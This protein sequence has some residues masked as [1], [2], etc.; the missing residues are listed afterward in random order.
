MKSGKPDSQGNFPEDSRDK[1]IT[2]DRLCDAYEA[3]LQEGSV[4]RGPFLAGVPADW[5]EQLTRELDAIDA[6]YRD[7][8]ETREQTLKADADEP[9]S[10]RL[11]TRGRLAELATLDSN[12][13]WLGRFEIRKRLGTGATGSVWCARDARL[14][15]WVALKVPHAT[16]V[17]SENTAARFQTEA[18]A[19]AAISHPNVVQVHEVLIEDGLPILI[20]QWIDGPSLAK[21]LKDT[22]QMDCDTAAD[23]MAQIADAV[24][25]AHDKGIVHRDLKPA[26]VMIAKNRP[27][28]LDFGLASYPQ[29]SSGLT[30]EGTVLGTPAYMSPEQ[31]EGAENANRPASD[32]YALGTILY[33]MLVGV[34][35]FVGKTREVLQSVKSSS[36]HAPRS[37]RAGIPR[38]LETIVLRCLSKSPAGR[39]QS[40]ADLRDDLRRFLRREPIHARKVSPLETAW[41][42][43]R[44][45]P[46]R[47][48]LAGVAPL[49]VVLLLA[50]V[51][52]QVRQQ[53]LYQEREAGK[54]IQ[55]ALLSQRHMIQLARASHELSDGDR[56]RG[57]ELL[58]SVPAEFRGW[59]WRLLDMI[60]HSPGQMLTHSLPAG[61]NQDSPITSMAVAR[62]QRKLFAASKEGII[63]RWSL[64]GDRMLFPRDRVAPIPVSEPE[65]IIQTP[66]MINAITVSPD[67]QWLAWVDQ[68]GDVFVWN[69]LEN[70]LAHHFPPE[71]YRRGYAIAFSPDSRN[72]I[73]AG[74]SVASA[75]YASDTRS[76]LVQWQLDDTGQFVANA[77]A[78]TNNRCAIT[79]LTFVDNQSFVCTRGQVITSTSSVGYVELWRLGKRRFAMDKQLWR[80]L[81]MH[82]ADFHAA[83][84]Q[85]GWCDSGGVAYIAELR[86]DEAPRQFHASRHGATQ[87]RFTPD[88]EQVVVVG[89]DGNVSRW[90]VG[91]PGPAA[92]ESSADEASG[93]ETSETDS[94]E[95]S[96]LTETK[97]ES[98]TEQPKPSAS[99]VSPTGRPAVRHLRDYHGH[100][101][102]VGSVVFLAPQPTARQ[103][104][105]Y[106]R[107]YAPQLIT[108][109][110][111]GRVM[112]WSQS[113]HPQID[114]TSLGDRLVSDATWLSDRQIAVSTVASRKADAVV[115]RATVLSQH[116]I[117]LDVRHARLS[118]SITRF[119]AAEENPWDHPEGDRSLVMPPRYAVVGRDRI[120][121]CETGNMLPLIECRPPSLSK[122]TFTAACLADENTLLAAISRVTTSRTKENGLDRTDRM[123]RTAFFVS[124]DLATGGILETVPL[125][126]TSV[127]TLLKRSP[128]NDQIF[129]ATNDGRLFVLPRRS[130]SEQT[131]QDV[132]LG[133]WQAHEG[134]RINDLSWI[135]SDG[136]LATVGD[137]GTCM[138][139]NPA[140]RDGESSSVPLG[141]RSPVTAA[142]DFAEG[143]RLFVS[144]VPVT[145]LHVSTTGERIATVSD[146]R[147][148]RIWDTETGLELIRLEA[149]KQPVVAAEF[150]PDDRHLMIAESGGRIETI[151]LLP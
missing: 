123:Q 61:V 139:W 131:L 96:D 30:S 16:R 9:C 94:G 113:D 46:A 121:V 98:A 4:E 101:N 12:R 13:V 28:V 102:V 5:R 75:K 73:A 70:E 142:M 141:S 99:K 138:L 134:H 58:R 136:R 10:R 150:S 17:M 71:R 97:T 88:G 127:V 60:S 36:P 151:Q 85:L 15:R 43:C 108:A 23:W 27:M 92:A 69:L 125:P 7:A 126:E 103:Q 119:P 77:L 50:M 140:G 11:P 135:G 83:T 2:I 1:W 146:D 114:T 26:N 91:V 110:E 148:I 78:R 67:E 25:C 74:G 54:T 147:V 18:R 84:Q 112:L 63:L 68:D 82:G 79:S 130:V 35:P 45:H 86:S 104:K 129:G 95:S 72:L 44:M 133:F 52:S 116:Q 144:G 41:A 19:A 145:S 24:A 76:W 93:T 34:P 40:A 32:I 48:L 57:L 59:E 31:A 81:A 124:Y 111:D 106:L 89:A 115:Y 65:V 66:A 64:P 100:E 22:G 149:R 42:W 118:E 105:P 47:A 3:S 90:Y 143:H 117:D 14:A 6:A 49:I 39:Y 51:A 122:V 38:D 37:R 33:E 137:D 62:N 20:Q 120:S 132:S 8:E 56:T 29:F 87:L 107:Y 53:R 55:K 109:G 128:Q 80:G 21:H